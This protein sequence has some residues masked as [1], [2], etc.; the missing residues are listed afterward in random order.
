MNAEADTTSERYIPAA[1]RQG[2][3]GLY[4]PAIALTMRERRFRRALVEQALAAEPG[5]IL[6]LG[7]GT[8]TLTVGLARAIPSARVIGLDGDPHALQRASHKARAASVEIELLQASATAI[9]LA[10]QSVGCVICSL[11]LHHLSPASKSLALRET[12]RVLRPGGLLLIAD[13][14]APHDRLMRVAF[15][16]VQA[17]DG[18]KNTRM[19]AMGQLPGLIERSGFA[20]APIE[21]LRTP[22]GSLELLAATAIDRDQC[23]PAA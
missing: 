12:H 14:G 21:Q 4:D 23:E 3:T 20:M 10:D 6:D 11:L 19:H 13:W 9:P 5:V 18:L 1:G 22:W 7:C 16:A 8:G 15:L 17:L 2:L